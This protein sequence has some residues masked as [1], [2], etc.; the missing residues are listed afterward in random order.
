MSLPIREYIAIPV[1]LTLLVFHASVTLFVAVK[2]H[3]RNASYRNA[4]FQLYLVQC[5]A[6]YLSYVTV[7][8]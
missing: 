4:F 3:R 2:V 1:E 6:N 7:S 5:A 8:I